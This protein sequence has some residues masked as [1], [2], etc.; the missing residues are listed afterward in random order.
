MQKFYSLFSGFLVAAVLMFGAGYVS[1]DGDEAT[2][3]AAT[4]IDANVEVKMVDMTAPLSKKAALETSCT[5][6]LG[7]IRQ[8]GNVLDSHCVTCTSFGCAP[9]FI[10]GDFCVTVGDDCTTRGDCSGGVD[11]IE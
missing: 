10:G 6:W 5:S 3:E 9:V 7:N 11:P 8:H 4:H 1:L 2:A